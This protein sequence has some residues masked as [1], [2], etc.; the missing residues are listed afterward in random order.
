MGNNRRQFEDWKAI[1]FSL[2]ILVNYRIGVNKH[3][4][5]ETANGK[6]ISFLGIGTY[7]GHPNDETDQKLEDTLLIAL[8]KGI[9]HIDTAP[10]YR[11]ERAELVIGNVVEKFGNRGD[12]FLAS[13]VGY[14][15]FERVIPKDHDR[16]F[17]ER[18]IDS[19][20]IIKN[21]L[22]NQNQCFDPR[23]I[24]WQV[25]ESIKRMK[26]GY[27]DLLYLHNF[28]VI[29]NA[30]PKE[31]VYS[32][33]Q[34]AIKKLID[35]YNEGLIKGFG[36]ASWGGFIFKD[37]N[38][39]LQ[40][41]DIYKICEEEKCNQGLVAIQFP[42]NL[43]MLDALFNKTQIFGE[44]KLTILRACD[45]LNVNSITSAPLM[46]GHIYDYQLSEGIEKI[47]H[48]TISKAKLALLFVKSTPNI[49]GTVVGVKTLEHLEDVIWANEQTNLDKSKYM[50]LLI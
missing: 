46:Q 10:V 31:K 4:K 39:L 14:L 6:K 19:G 26:C 1:Y 29:F 28:E 24:D 47:F 36:F 41:N 27:L 5:L 50:A 2:T 34:L 16:Y 49:T 35:L 30:L 12:L 33:M 3:M 13:K 37:S 32:I 17:K 43:R 25:R 20:I 40:L 22:I 18:F 45:R 38:L 44:D 8:Q 21:D 48:K 42:F 15:P 11:A 9:N 23:Y 7:L